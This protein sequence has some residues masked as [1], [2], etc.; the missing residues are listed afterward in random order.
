[1][2]FCAIG[3]L[4]SVGLLYALWRRYFSEVSAG[5]VAA[6]A[7]AL[8]LATIVPVLL[9]RCDVYEWRSV[10]GICWSC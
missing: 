5:V 9:S 7:L 3:F 1:M 2:I 4:A 10:A 8:G 6:C